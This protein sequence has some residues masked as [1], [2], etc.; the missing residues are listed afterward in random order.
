MKQF[1]LPQGGNWYKA[2]LHVHTTCSDGLGTPE[3]IK[4]MY[5]EKGYSIVAY[6]DHEVV[7]PHNDLR[8]ENF[9]PITGAEI[10][11]NKNIPGLSYRYS[12]QY[13]LNILSKDPEKTD[14]S[15]FL[16]VSPGKN[17]PVRLHNRI[18]KKKRLGV[19][20]SLF[21]FMLLRM[22]LSSSALRFLLCRLSCAA[23]TAAAP[24][25][26]ATKARITKTI[27][28]VKI[29]IVFTSLLSYFR[30]SLLSMVNSRLC[31][32]VVLSGLSPTLAALGRPPEGPML[33]LPG[34]GR[35]RTKVS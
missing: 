24:P 1:L 28:P 27:S 6:T 22:I 19:G 25:K 11:V 13:H 30:V 21:Y 34:L 16:G 29:S 2:C 10:S 23:Q 18:Q 32:T 9:L 35:R 3:E 26:I 14:F 33:F 7:I 20:P 12:K 4:K 8:D 31:I 17:G 15:F 5:T